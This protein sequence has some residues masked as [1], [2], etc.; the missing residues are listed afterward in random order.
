MCALAAAGAAA[1]ATATTAACRWQA[2]ARRAALLTRSIAGTGPPRAM[3]RFGSVAAACVGGVRS[4]RRC[5]QA[6][7]PPWARL[8][9]QRLTVLV[10]SAIAA[11]K[12]AFD[13][14]QSRRRCCVAAVGPVLA[15]TWRRAGF[16]S[17]RVSTD[18]ETAE[19][20]CYRLLASG[21]EVSTPLRTPL[22]TP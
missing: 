11:P 15:Q 9:L 8:L 6:P 21:L 20:L 16:I 13:G 1:P 4:R 5:G 12:A 2:R 3:R 17:Y 22:R 19:D 10:L 7:L 18:A 14:A